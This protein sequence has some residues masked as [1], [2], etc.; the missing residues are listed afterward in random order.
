MMQQA[1]YDRIAQEYRDSKQL[2]FRKHIEA[3][4][5]FRMAGSVRQ[6]R[7]LDLACGEGFYTRLFKCAGAAEVVGVDLSSEM[8]ELAEATERQH[9]LGCRYLVHD[10]ASLPHLGTFDR[11]VAVYLLNYAQNAQQLLD[12]CR[13]A[14][15]QLRP[16]GH[17]IGFNDNLAN[18][19]QHYPTYAKYG[20]TKQCRAQRQEGDAIRYT[21]YNADGTTF[22]FN[23]YYLH[24]ETYAEAFTAAG[25]T[26]FR[27]TGALLDPEQPDPAFW[28]DFLVDP[29]VVG[30]RAYKPA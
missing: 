14:Y 25:F 20:F 27:W 16:G 4:S 8:I 30:F 7:V 13:A 2:P 15:R 12:F 17:F 23:N 11:V 1:E 6:L 26:D 18:D 24:P 3:Y 19:P 9:P 10:V 28:D 22:A 21:F 5:L 29:P